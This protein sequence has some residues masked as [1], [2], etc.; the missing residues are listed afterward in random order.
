MYSFIKNTLSSALGV[1]LAIG[2]LGVI[3]FIFL[4]GA[5]ASSSETT[6]IKNKYH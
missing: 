3:G 5:A 1:I 2:V 4:I 6:S